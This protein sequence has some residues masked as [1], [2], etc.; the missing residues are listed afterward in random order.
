MTRGKNP[1]FR[2]PVDADL[3]HLAVE[4]RRRTNL[5]QDKLTSATSPF[6]CLP[7][8]YLTSTWSS[9]LWFDISTRWVPVGQGWELL[10][11][12][13]PGAGWG[14]RL[15][16]VGSIAALP[17]GA[18]RAAAPPSCPAALPGP[19]SPVSSVTGGAGDVQG[20][21]SS[22]STLTVTFSPLSYDY[23]FG[24]NHQQT[25]WSRAQAEGVPLSHFNPPGL[26]PQPTLNKTKVSGLQIRQN[27]A[28]LLQHYQIK[29]RLHH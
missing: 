7:S 17:A 23:Q 22:P 19:D 18:C 1:L 5:P 8:S 10:S 20:C 3:P 16:P 2:I 25:K 26:A 29:P 21:L 24:D 13:P 12:S 27:A 11:P 15:T 9:A 6:P 4:L 28:T 14:Q